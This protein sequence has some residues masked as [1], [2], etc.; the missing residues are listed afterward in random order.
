MANIIVTPQLIANFVLKS[1]LG[2]LVYRDLVFNA[3]LSN[4]MVSAKAGDTV[5]VKIPSKF[6]MKRY[7]GSLI[8]QNLDE[9]SIPVKLDIIGDITVPITSKEMTLE[10][11]DFYTQ[12]L[13]PIGNGIALGIDGYIAN[14]IYTSVPATNVVPATGSA[15]DLKDIAQLGLK[16]DLA[17]APKQ[18]RRLVLS[19]S[20]KVKYAVTQNLSAVAYAG[21]S[22][23]LRDALLGRVYGFE[24]LESNYNPVGAGGGTAVKATNVVVAGSAGS[25]TVAVNGLNTATATLKKGDIIIVDGQIITVNDDATASGS[26]IASLT[27]IQEELEDV[28]NGTY[29]DVAISTKDVSLAFSDIAFGLVNVPLELPMNNPNSAIASYNGVSV[30]VFYGYDQNTKTQ[31]LSVDTLFGFAKFYPETSAVLYGN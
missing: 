7:H 18:G 23:T 24:T 31:K 20:H 29:T 4:Q 15:T 9:S 28:K 10:I 2:N 5:N 22:V 26:N 27:V 11:N 17:K 30:R 1:L 16:L 12:V 8:E 14:K 21:D 25:K 19:P 13:E 3:E 6:K